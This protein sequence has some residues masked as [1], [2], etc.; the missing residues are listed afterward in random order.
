MVDP[1]LIPILGIVFAVGVP[2]MALATHFVLRPMVRDIT[3]AIQA[4]KQSS[5]NADTEERL[6]RLEDAYYNLD[7]QVTRLVE[8]EEF[9]RQLEAGKRER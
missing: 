2:T 8:A 4:N 9:R 1:I 7:R 5:S 3:Q 6:A